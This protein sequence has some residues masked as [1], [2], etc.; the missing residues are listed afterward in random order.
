MQN[1]NE[2]RQLCALV[3]AEVISDRAA[4]STSSAPFSRLISAP[5]ETLFSA[6]SLQETSETPHSTPPT[7]P[8]PVPVKE[9]P[10]DP[11]K[12]PSPE[13]PPPE[14]PPIGPQKTP[15]TPPTGTDSCQARRTVLVVSEMRLIFL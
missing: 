4:Q 6:G 2:K 9:P 14:M 1:V 13:S 5:M 10:A 8:S 11:T 15:P 12:E 3:C 7:S